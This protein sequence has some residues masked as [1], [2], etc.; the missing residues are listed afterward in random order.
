MG[1]GSGNRV[2]EDASSA[3]PTKGPADCRNDLSR[4]LSQGVQV[5][6]EVY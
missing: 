5:C 2:L 1:K 3:T 4:L 6:T